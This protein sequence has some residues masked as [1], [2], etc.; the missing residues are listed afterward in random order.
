MIPIGGAKGAMLV[1]MVEIL[2]A[3]LTGSNFGYEASSS[4]AAT[5]PAP[6]IGQFLLLL[7]PKPFSGDSFLPR[8]EVL[9]SLMTA[10]KGV[11]LPGDRR[12]ERRKAAEIEG[13]SLPQAIHEELVKRV[14]ATLMRAA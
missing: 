8:L 9:L 11:R 5:G 4:Y 13:I 6:R 3:A 7:D 12:L 2:S 1:L 10:Q 14:P